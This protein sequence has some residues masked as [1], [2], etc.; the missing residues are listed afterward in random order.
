MITN[1][2]L[3]VLLITA[4]LLIN[5]VNPGIYGI[6]NYQYST[7]IMPQDP[8]SQVSSV[9]P[10]GASTDQVTQWSIESV[11][12]PDCFQCFKIK[13]V[14]TGG[15]LDANDAGE[16]YTNAGNDG[17]NQVWYAYTTDPSQ[18]QTQFYNFATD[19]CLDQT[20]D[21]QVI[22][23]GNKDGN[24]QYWTLQPVPSGKTTTKKRVCRKLRGSR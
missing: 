3:F 7:F 5:C 6:V 12:F 21:N 23:H 18:P 1:L 17:A 2:P 4:P 20:S 24:N 16:L 15:F 19:Q 9:I 8:N 14:V 13:N 11:D 22:T 10:G